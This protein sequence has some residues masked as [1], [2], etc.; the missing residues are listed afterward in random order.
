[1]IN[2]GDVVKFNGYVFGSY[3]KYNRILIDMKLK[4]PKYGVVIGYSF[5][6]TGKIE[7]DTD[8]GYSYSYLFLPK[9]HKVWVIEPLD[10][11]NR[12]LKPYRVFEKNIEV[13]MP[14][15]Q[16]QLEVLK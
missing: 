7:S 6:R 12:Y 11:G 10:K 2:K 14:F 1:M 9:D 16:A 13:I 3:K 5:L 8:W 15:N 4:E